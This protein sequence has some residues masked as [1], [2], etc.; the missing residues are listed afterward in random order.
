MDYGRIENRSRS[1]FSL[2][3]SLASSNLDSY[4]LQFI[5]FGLPMEMGYG[6]SCFGISRTMFGYCQLGVLGHSSL[7]LFDPRCDHTIH[8]SLFL[9]RRGTRSHYKDRDGR[10]C[11]VDPQ[12][13]LCLKHGS[14]TCIPSVVLILLCKC[15]LRCGLTGKNSFFMILAIIENEESSRVLLKHNKLLS[16]VFFVLLQKGIFG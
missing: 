11:G 10:N 12:L 8:E 14:T 4:F 6:T 5:T 15:K 1:D 13:H 9:R 3:V 2:I 16:L 7:G